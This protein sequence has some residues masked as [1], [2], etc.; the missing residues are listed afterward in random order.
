ML[1]SIIIVD[2]KTKQIAHK[3]KASLTHP[4]WEIIVVDNTRY[5]RGY[6]GGINAGVAK[7][8]GDFLLFLNP[9]VKIETAQVSQLLQV[10][11][12]NP[13][14]GVVG[15]QFV[16]ARGKIVP[17][18]LGRLSYLGAFSAL[19]VLH[20]TFPTRSSRHFWLSDWDRRE[21]KEVSVVN[22]ACM[23]MR[24]QDFDKLGGFDEAFF[25]YWEENDFCLRLAKLGKTVL[26][27]PQVSVMHTRAVSVSQSA[28]DLSKVFRQSRFL[29][30]QKYFG[31]PKATLLQVFIWTLEHARSIFIFFSALFFR[32]ISPTH[33]RI[34]DDVRR[35]YT[36]GLDMLA[37]KGI[38]LLGIPSSV[39]RFAQ[40]PLNIWF[41]ALSF[42]I[43]GRSP[44]ATVI[45]AGVV[46]SI[47]A[48]CLYQMLCRYI[49]RNSALFAALWFV[50]SPAAVFQ[51]RMPFYLFM[52]PI[53]TLILLQAID[54][55]ASKKGHAVFFVVLAFC[56]LLQ[57]EL[58]T[59]P[60]LAVVILAIFAHRIKVVYFW[61]WILAALVLGL[62]PQILFDLR[63][64]CQQICHFV[65]WM[66]YRTVAVS[67]I[68]GRH[69]FKLFS[70]AFWQSVVTQVNYLWGTNLVPTLIIGATIMLGVVSAWRKKKVHKIFHWSL[71]SCA[72]LAV[73]LIIHG[74]PSEAYFPPFLTLIPIMI[75]FSLWLL[76]SRI[77]RPLII[78]MLISMTATGISVVKNIL[79]IPPLNSL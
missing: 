6:G 27:Y 25:M 66:G 79:S 41:D 71:I 65:A 51:S 44:Q 69:G 62:A 47:G 35:D 48:W 56:F 46:T 22:G 55:L 34:I 37:G 61:K 4:D 30:F 64:G 23:M 40:G 73:G 15:P 77:Q 45:F 59:I 72:L 8:C 58:A 76:P 19:S 16:D 38:P 60:F 13:R 5:N 3:L 24:R 10:L 9:D 63:N 28:D 1:L 31:L 17:S 43:G 54:N 57:W 14:A 78:L 68:D 74:T 7:S 18:C 26:Y 50:V 75:G 11:R 12:K 32:L 67:G 2:F 39:P 29:F 53:A 20:Q 49:S 21:P 36:L 52:I 70:L 33:I 42:G